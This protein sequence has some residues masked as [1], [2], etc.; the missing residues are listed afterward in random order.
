MWLAAQ[1]PR[2]TAWR[3]GVGSAPSRFLLSPYRGRASQKRAAEE[4]KTLEAIRDFHPGT[5]RPERRDLQQGKSCKKLRRQ[6][7]RT[8]EQ[9][10]R[11]SRSRSTTAVRYL[12]AS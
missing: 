4:A 1:V 7:R 3:A 8:T 10:G 6:V 12:Q 11:S 5:R 2:H 9:G